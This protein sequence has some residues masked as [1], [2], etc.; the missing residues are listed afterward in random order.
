MIEDNRP[1]NG[2]LDIKLIEVNNSPSFIFHDK[3]N[4]QKQS[5]IFFQALDKY[6]FSKVF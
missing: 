5:E 4:N 1:F 3:S 6:I 2:G